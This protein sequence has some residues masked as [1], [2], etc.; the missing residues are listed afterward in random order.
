M[1]AFT[2][3]G[4]KKFTQEVKNAAN[5]MND[6]NKAINS[7]HESLKDHISHSISV[8][9]KGISAAAE[10]IRLISDAISKNESRKSE[11]EAEIAN[12]QSMRAS[13]DPNDPNASQKNSQISAA[14]NSKE[15]SIRQI[16]ANISRL[17][18]MRN[19]IT[20]E[21]Q[22]LISHLSS[23]KNCKEKIYNVF[24]AYHSAFKTNGNVIYSCIDR[25][26]N[27]RREAEN[28]VRC[29]ASINSDLWNSSEIVFRENGEFLKRMSSAIGN[30]TRGHS[31]SVRS[32]D[33]ARFEYVSSITDNV[34]KDAVSRLKQHTGDIEDS[35][36]TLSSYGESCR[37]AY[38]AVQ[39]YL[40]CA[41]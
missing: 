37:L 12:L 19:E 2:V 21:R 18:S 23:L 6:Q 28:I 32:L 24:A 36:S 34:R 26:E 41:R 1:I 8:T 27:A 25:S 9:E 3:E 14:I 17:N 38:Q 10:D 33:S 20:A 22:R 15:S 40:F 29:V 16:N 39:N 5:A 11:T 4:I 7:E 35:V 31:Y 13:I 30:M